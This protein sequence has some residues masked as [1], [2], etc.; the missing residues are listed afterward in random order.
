MDKPEEKKTRDDLIAEIG[1]IGLQK[2]VLEQVQAKL[3]EECQLRAERIVQLDREVQVLRQ[4][5][6][7]NARA[8]AG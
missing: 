1:E 7:A 5:A 8:N 4:A 6:Q 2:R 3:V